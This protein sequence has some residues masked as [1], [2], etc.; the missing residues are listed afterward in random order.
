[1][2]LMMVNVG[3]LLVVFLHAPQG[4]VPIMQTNTGDPSQWV[5]AVDMMADLSLLAAEL[6]VLAFS[7]WLLFR[8]TKATEYE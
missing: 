4:G 3:R 1:M 8:M 6:I 5:S 2:L 7:L